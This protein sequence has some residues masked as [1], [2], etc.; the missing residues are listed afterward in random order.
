MIDYI[1]MTYI[2]YIPFIDLQRPYF[3]FSC[4]ILTGR[5]KRHQ[6]QGGYSKDRIPGGEAQRSGDLP[7]W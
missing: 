2:A 3:H 6:A 7:V 4:R 5:R 1:Y